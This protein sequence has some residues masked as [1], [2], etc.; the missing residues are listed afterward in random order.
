MGTFLNQAGVSDPF[1]LS[2]ERKTAYAVRP[3]DPEKNRD[4]DATVEDAG[5]ATVVCEYSVFRV[6]DL[7]IC[8]SNHGTSSTNDEFKLDLCQAFEGDSCG[9]TLDK[10]L[11]YLNRT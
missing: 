5:L 9:G 7:R 2:P 6:P 11:Y 1:G 3:S 8:S 4:L 10:F